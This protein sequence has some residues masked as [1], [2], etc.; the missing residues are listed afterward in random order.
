MSKGLKV[1][2]KAEKYETPSLPLS[3]KVDKEALDEKPTPMLKRILRWVCGFF[4]SEKQLKNP[5]YNFHPILDARLTKNKD[6]ELLDKINFIF[7]H[8]EKHLSSSIAASN[9]LKEKFTLLFTY[10]I[11]AIPFLFFKVVYLTH[12][13]APN[14]IIIF[15]GSLIAQYLVIAIIGIRKGFLPQ[16]TPLLGNEPKNL[17]SEEFLNRSEI[18]MKIDQLEHYQSMIEVTIKKNQ[19]LS[20]IIKC[21]VLR[22]VC[23][24]PIISIVFALV[25]LFFPIFI[26]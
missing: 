14:Y 8:S 17:L 12:A 18:S 16:Y 7:N 23:I 15:L 20:K 2:N 24:S 9:R 25:D 21:S 1:D 5:P 22:L 13:H 11:T 6:K 4:I 26:K 3:E 19:E 10:V